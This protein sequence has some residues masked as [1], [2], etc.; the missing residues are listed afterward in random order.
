MSVM[1]VF[2]YD[3]SAQDHFER[4]PYCAKFHIFDA[5]FEEFNYISCFETVEILWIRLYFFYK[6]LEILHTLLTVCRIHHKMLTLERCI[7]H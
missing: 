5:G 4:Q 3:D 2:T 1:E 7:D 6:F